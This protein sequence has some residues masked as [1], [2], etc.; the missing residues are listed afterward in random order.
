MERVCAIGGVADGVARL[1]DANGRTG[2]PAGACHDVGGGRGREMSGG[3]SVCVRL[4]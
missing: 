4:A 2:Q 1:C 3:W